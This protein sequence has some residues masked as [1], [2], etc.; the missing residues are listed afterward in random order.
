MTDGVPPQQTSLAQRIVT[1]PRLND[2]ALA[3]MRVHAWLEELE[4][5]ERSEIGEQM[6]AA[7]LTETV[8]HGIAESSPFLWDLVS[9]DAQRLLRL[10]RSDPDSHFA[11]VLAE[12]TSDVARTDD[13]DTAMRLLRRMK[14]EAA[15]L[16]ALADIGGAWPVMRAAEA[17]S[18]RELPLATAG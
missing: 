18:E 7:P 4:P 12:T 1:A 5:A 3:A 2:A 8:L 15:L 16:I 14:A 17:L 10:L 9:R 6:R 11:R 13:L